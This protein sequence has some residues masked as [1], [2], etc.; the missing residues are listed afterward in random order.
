MKTLIYSL[1]LINFLSACSAN[2]AMTG[3]DGPDMIQV[4]QQQKRNTVELLLGLPIKEARQPNGNIVCQ[5]RFDAKIEPDY[6]KGMLY[7]T[8]DMYTF[9]LWEV[10]GTPIEVNANRKRTAW[11]EYSADGQVIR[12]LEDGKLFASSK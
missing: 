1:L 7:A 3:K 12:I 11:V 6:A 4:K 5:Y 10:V 2:M 9:G 8:M